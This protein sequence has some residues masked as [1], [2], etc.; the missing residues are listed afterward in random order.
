M[1]LI[2][3]PIVFCIIGFGLLYGQR[4]NNEKLPL[5]LTVTPLKTSFKISE[6][7][8]YEIRIENVSKDTFIIP[9]EI[10]GHYYPK[11]IASNGEEVKWEY[12]IPT[13]GG[14]NEKNT[15]ELGPGCFYGKKCT[16]TGL[17]K[18]GIYTFS[19]VY[20]APINLSDSL[21]HYWNDQLESN[22]VQITVE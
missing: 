14:F 9:E 20:N 3:R 22:K 16:W 7:W 4:D 5:I 2:F 12:A 1:K 11:M 15:I 21:P 8:K 19:I 17:K 18:P 10:D 13:M 6:K